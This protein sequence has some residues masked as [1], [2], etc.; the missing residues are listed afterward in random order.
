ML[1]AKPKHLRGGLDATPPKKKAKPKRSGKAARDLLTRAV[2]WALAND[3]AQGRTPYPSAKMPLSI[4]KV[5]D[6]DPSTDANYNPVGERGE[7]RH[8]PPHNLSEEDMIDRMTPKDAAR[9]SEGWPSSIGT[10]VDMSA[11]KRGQ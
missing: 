5:L 8:T 11:L 1:E 10:L 2:S 6:A 7:H 3:I 4:A 9:Y